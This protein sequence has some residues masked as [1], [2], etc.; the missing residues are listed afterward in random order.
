MFAISALSHFRETRTLCLSGRT[1]NN[2]GALVEIVGFRTGKKQ[3]VQNMYAA[4]Q[5]GH[6][7]TT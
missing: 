5:K 1:E 7:P 6:M 3:D 4:S 2:H